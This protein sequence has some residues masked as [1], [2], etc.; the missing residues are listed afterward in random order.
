MSKFRNLIVPISS[1]D[2]Q[3]EWYMS[4]SEYE[5]N[6]KNRIAEKM[7]SKIKNS[8]YYQ[9]YIHFEI[10]T[11]ELPV[12]YSLPEGFFVFAGSEQHNAIKKHK[13]LL[14]KRSEINRQLEEVLEIVD[15]PLKHSQRP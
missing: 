3:Y 14:K 5:R 2:P 10:F 12:R 9:K 4:F 1:H 6:D 7:I 11:E 13:V 8:T 15:L